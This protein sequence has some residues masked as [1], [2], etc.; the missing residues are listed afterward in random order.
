MF[1][2][3]TTWDTAINDNILSEEHFENL[4]FSAGTGRGSYLYLAI[5]TLSRDPV[6][7]FGISKKNLI[8]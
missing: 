7:L 4:K 2:Y 8:Q 1:F 3:L 5:F 6:P